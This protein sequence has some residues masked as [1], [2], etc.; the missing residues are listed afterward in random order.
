MMQKQHVW[1]VLAVVMLALTARGDWDVGDDCKMHYPQTP[2][3]TGWDIDI[4]RGAIADDFMC[5]QTG[6][7]DDIHFWISWKDDAIGQVQEVVAKIYSDIPA[8]QDPNTTFSHPGDLLWTGLFTSDMLTIRDAGSG[9][10]GWYSPFTN[11]LEMERED[12]NYYQQINIDE[13]DNPCYQTKGTI[14]WLSLEVIPTSTS[15]YFVG[16]KTANTPI[17]N[18][19]AVY[20]IPDPAGG[21]T[22]Y[23]LLGFGATTFEPTDLAFVITPEP[24]T[25]ISLV[26]GIVALTSRRR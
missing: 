22:T 4:T 21:P 14:Y 17:F 16:W 13:I 20:F 7:I 23:G 26:I 18:D 2:N 10:Q 11:P 15:N 12:H 24:T 8:G 19:S 6:T 5:T 3:P 1:S 9:K 25:I